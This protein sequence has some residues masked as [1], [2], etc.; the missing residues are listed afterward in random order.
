MPYLADGDYEEV[1]RVLMHQRNQ[2]ERSP[3]LLANMEEEAA[4]DILLIG[5][6]GQ[7]EGRAVGEAFNR[8]GKTDILIRE[9]D[10]N[11]FVGECKFWRGPATIGKTLD[12]LFNRY[13]TWRDTKAALLLF[14]RDAKS[15]TDVIT[16][17]QQEFKEHPS[18]VSQAPGTVPNERYNYVYTAPTDPQ[19]R[20]RLAFLPFV[21]A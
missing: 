18:F 20:V 6:N 17:A 12:Q 15:P 10:R 4:R 19:Q 9:G 11:V 1:L 13:L 5:L 16:K 3:S 21:F 7:F 14:I 8:S 2:F